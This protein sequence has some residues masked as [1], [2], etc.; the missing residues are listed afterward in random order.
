MPEIKNVF[1]GAKMNKDLDERFVPNG[2]YRDAMNI[3][4][5]TSDGGNAG[6]VQN[7]QG[8]EAV[9]MLNGDEQYHRQHNSSCVGHVADEANNKSYWFMSGSDVIG[10]GPSSWVFPIVN[11]HSFADTIYEYNADTNRLTIVVNDVYAVVADAGSF[12]TTPSTTNPYGSITISATLT[13]RMRKGCRIQAYNS[14]NVPLFSVPPTVNQISSNTLQLDKYYTDNLTTADKYV[15]W[16]EPVLELDYNKQVTAINVVD[17]YLFWTDGRNEPKKL[18]I[19]RSIAGSATVN[20]NLT[21]HTKL[22]V[23]N[24]NGHLVQIDV[25]EPL[26]DPYLKKEHITVIRPAPRTAPR[27]EMSRSTRGVD[28][29]SGTLSQSFVSEGVPLVDEELVNVQINQPGA[30]LVVGDY[31]NLSQ[32]GVVGYEE[33]QEVRVVVTNVSDIS[34]GLIDFEVLSVSSSTTGVM[35]EWIWSLEDKKS[36]YELEFGRFAYRYKYVDGEY[37]S[38]SPWSELAFLPGTFDY[39]TRTG[40]N[41]AMENKV[42]E[43]KVT[44]FV[45]NDETRPDDVDS[46]D[47]LYKKT[48]DT[49]VYVVKTIK[50]DHDPEW[51]IQSNNVHQTQGEIIITSEMVHMALPSSQLLRSWDAV[52]RYAKAQEIT[53]SRLVYGNYCQ[54]YDVPRF[55]ASQWISSVGLKTGGLGQKSVK[56][57]RDY[58]I[59]I[60]FG[61]KYGRE[62]PVQEVGG[63]AKYNPGSGNYSYLPTD[64]RCEKVNS[65]NQ[66]S[67]NIQQHWSTPQGQSIVPPSWM[68]Y[69]KYYVKETSQ[70]YYNLVM[71]RWYDAE[72][73]NVWISFPSVDRNKVDEETHITLKKANG[74]NIAVDEDAR[75]KILAISNSAPDFIKREGFVVGSVGFTSGITS[76]DGFE[77]FT[78]ISHDTPEYNSAI[79]NLNVS[80]TRY[81][82]VVGSDNDDHLHKSQ[83]V[84]VIGVDAGST[85][86]EVMLMSALGPSADMDQVWI[87]NGYG[88]TP[89]I[90]VEYKVEDSIEKSEFEGR[91]FVK[92]LKDSTLQDH[93]MHTTEDGAFWAVL[94]TFNVAFLGISS[95]AYGNW[96]ESSSESWFTGHGS[97]NIA[98][99][100]PDNPGPYN[101]YVVNTTAGN[102]W[103]DNVTTEFEWDLDVDDN[104]HVQMMG[105]CPGRNATKKFWEAYWAHKPATWWIDNTRF[106]HTTNSVSAED[107]IYYNGNPNDPSPEAAP[108]GLHDSGLVGS[109]KDLLFFSRFRWDVGNDTTLVQDLMQTPGTFFRFKKDPNQYVYKVIN[110]SSLHFFTN[111]DDGSGCNEYDVLSSTNTAYDW[112]SLTRRTFWFMFRKVDNFSGGTLN[113][114]LDTS[115]WDPR[116]EVRHD[117]QD[118]QTIEIVTPFMQQGGKVTHFSKAA[119]WE[120]EPKESVDIDIYYEATD[121]LPMSL[122]ETNVMDYA[123]TGSIA[124]YVRR[125]TEVL[126][127]S[128]TAIVT[129]HKYGNIEFKETQS[130]NPTVPNGVLY[131]NFLIGDV[132]KLTHVN[133]METSVVIEDHVWHNGSN[134]TP[135]LTD[136]ITD[137][138]VVMGPYQSGSQNVIFGDQ[139][140]V[141][142][143]IAMHNQGWKILVTHPDLLTPTYV[144]TDSSNNTI[145]IDPSET[146]LGFAITLTNGFTTQNPN[147]GANSEEFT[148]RGISGLYQVQEDVY[149]LPVKL[150]WFNCYSFGNGV[151]SDRI[152][153]DFNAPQIDNG[154]KAST[155][156]DDYGEEHRGSGL[157]YSGLFNSNSSLNNLNE[158]NTSEK[159]TKDLNPAHGSIQALK[160]RDTN[161]VAFCEDKVL[162]ILSNKDAVFNADGNP[163]LTATDKVLGQAIPFAGDYG[164]SSNPESLACDQ[165]RMYFSDKQ[166]GAILRLSNDGITPIS[167]VGMK[168]WFRDNLALAS[169]I[170]GTFDVVNGEYNVTISS[171]EH[172]AHTLES[173]TVS[174]NEASKGWVS[175]KSFIPLAGGSVAGQYLTSG[176]TSGGSAGSQIWKHY[177]SNHIFGSFANI[178]YGVATPSS[179]T[180]IFNDNP[181]Y[182]KTFMSLNYEGSASKRQF[183]TAKTASVTDAAGNS[184]S[185][186]DGNF[187]GISGTTRDGWYAESITTDMQSGSVPR[188]VEKEGKYFAN[189]VGASADVNSFCVQ[190][191]GEAA[192]VSGD[193][194]NNNQVLTITG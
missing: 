117:G 11:L 39:E 74:Q 153:D 65:E 85:I 25:L 143:I 132:V 128:P 62:T 182:V 46:I 70:E 131:R 188:F 179:I 193:T 136:S 63:V 66:N 60:V 84:R 166:R 187:I 183:T 95:R 98:H 28:L 97:Y 119:I 61:D 41:L 167:N 189:I 129:D 53:A 191:I 96:I 172:S 164:I 110:A 43:I 175:F 180:L 135:I 35:T 81:A 142:Q 171:D 156:L 162:K 169:K 22:K 57:I 192:S 154:C 121:A 138:A 106:A 12:V 125:G 32:L 18:S 126:A 127:I 24:G 15:F 165:Y 78:S 1:T 80:G 109:D 31:L 37:S 20:T 157:I 122:N 100:D 5:R 88:G 38:F 77:N 30:D 163:N 91:F 152:R 40:Y 104:D 185:A 137:T 42:K 174:F 44:H 86:T 120:T 82:R 67:I 79:G 160:T 190:G 186:N 115:I 149:E 64:L 158:F 49:G 23:K 13:E 50:R 141:N 54:N 113:A 170:L 111:Y 56:S 105:R 27:L 87:D 123:P 144:Q 178:F 73:G 148:F 118:A 59:G 107:T 45:A 139:A 76:T 19:S 51:D 184:I 101:N 133:G 8:N 58:R 34:D 83:W 161:V 33:A 130:A 4:V 10:L 3:Q 55:S 29:I 68:D 146:P 94:E 124:N 7:L 6:V 155:V 93:V 159:I 116:G 112:T 168:E 134:A 69:C 147:N 52:P 114:G 26:T 92:I 16:W 181:S 48:T 75:Y 102:T 71:D 145:S 177:L 173:Q 2:Q 108:Y 140:L 14:S 194:T 151:E 47:I 72:D 89:D 90:T 9:R 150:P 99:S 21:K 17:D 176:N 103:F 36:M